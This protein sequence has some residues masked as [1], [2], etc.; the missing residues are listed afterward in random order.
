MYFGK[1][2]Q[3]IILTLHMFFP[4]DDTLLQYLVCDQIFH[5]VGQPGSSVAGG[6]NAG[7]ARPTAS[8]SLSGV[9]P[10][11]RL[12]TDTSCCASQIAEDTV[13]NYVLISP[14]TSTSP[15]PLNFSLTPSC[16]SSP[17]WRGWH[18]VH[19]AFL[20][21]RFSFSLWFLHVWRTP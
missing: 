1:S 4:L 10:S 8:L 9:T 14:P 6:D 15:P 19:T 13:R 20:H 5:S 21:T 2:S 7:H 16:S 3:D 12:S 11:A 17:D 18:R